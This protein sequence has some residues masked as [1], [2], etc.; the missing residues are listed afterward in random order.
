MASGRGGDPRTSPARSPGLPAGEAE[1]GR[2]DRGLRA[3]GIVLCGGA[4]TRMGRD[5]AG[6]ELERMTLLGRALATLDELAAPVRLACGPAARY[7][8]SGRALCLDRWSDGGPLAGLE[9]GLAAAAPGPVC[10][11]AVDI[12]LPSSAPLRQLLERLVA[13]DLDAALLASARGPEPLCGVYH[14][15]VLP[16][17]RA[18]LERGERKVIRWHADALAGRALRIAWVPARELGLGDE[19]LNLNTPEDLARAASPVSPVSTTA[20]QRRAAS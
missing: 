7:A 10:V 20:G 11:V 8:D 18:A 3:E 1:G 2:A 16:L 5:K 9:A 12:V 4:S 14:T 6:V 15:R 19:L 13:G 17:V